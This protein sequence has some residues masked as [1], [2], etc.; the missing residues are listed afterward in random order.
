MYQKCGFIDKMGNA[1]IRRI[2]Y[3]AEFFSTELE[4]LAGVRK[5]GEWHHIGL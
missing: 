1:V 3:E 5:D 2:Y 4:G